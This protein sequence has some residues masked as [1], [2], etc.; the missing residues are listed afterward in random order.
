MKQ[1]WKPLSLG[2][3]LAVSALA[4]L[5]L[6][7]P[8]SGDAQAARGKSAAASES[9]SKNGLRQFTGIVTAF[10]KTTLTVVNT[11]SSRPPASWRRMPTSRSTTAMKAS[12]P[13]RIA[14]W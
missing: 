7:A 4:L 1:G 2:V 6:V 8:R 5:P 12:R 3:A 14:W 9:K 13:W 11:R 10:D